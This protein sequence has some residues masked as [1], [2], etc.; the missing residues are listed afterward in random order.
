MDATERE[1]VADLIASVRTLASQTM[2]LHLHLGALRSLLVE[3][4]LISEAQFTA[5]V[6][7]LEAS[8]TADAMTSRHAPTVDDV[9][10][11]L[12][13]RLERLT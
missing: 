9:F 10:D 6:T 7:A 5:A 4:G 1:L 13:R 8:S 11:H 2:L 3:A 12:L